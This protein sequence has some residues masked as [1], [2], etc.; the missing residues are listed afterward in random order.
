MG[1]YEYKMY[2]EERNIKNEVKGWGLGVGVAHDSIEP[3]VAAQFKN[4]S[5]STHLHKFPRVTPK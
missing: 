1:Y 5:R 2:F 3:F 4:N